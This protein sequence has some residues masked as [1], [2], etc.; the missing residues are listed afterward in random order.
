MSNRIVVEDATN[1]LF[2]LYGNGPQP[3][4]HA[5][6][7]MTNF[8]QLLKHVCDVHQEVIDDDCETHVNHTIDVAKM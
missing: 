6:S 5:T 7:E 3:R 4:L 1:F 2:Q 8:R